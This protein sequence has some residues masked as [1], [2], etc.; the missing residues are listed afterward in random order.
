MTAEWLPSANA[1]FLIAIAHPWWQPRMFGS[2][3]PNSSPVLSRISFTLA[4]PIEKRRMG[5]IASK[6]ILGISSSLIA[7]SN[8]HNYCTVK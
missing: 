4:N 1:C 7:D 3:W 8:L 2:I 6:V 5:H